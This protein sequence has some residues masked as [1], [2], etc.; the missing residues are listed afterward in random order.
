MVI[1]STFVGGSMSGWVR[2]MRIIDSLFD[3]FEFRGATVED[4]SLEGSDLEGALVGSVHWSSARCP[5]GTR[6]NDNLG[7][8]EG[9][10][11]P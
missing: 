3:A 10:L 7:T 4:S 9:H 5:D 2:T 11:S 8:C 1:D 6:S